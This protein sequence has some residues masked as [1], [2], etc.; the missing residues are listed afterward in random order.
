M[1]ALVNRA[2]GQLTRGCMVD[3]QLAKERQASGHPTGKAGMPIVARCSKCAQGT[4]PPSPHSVPRLGV[5]GFARLAVCGH[6]FI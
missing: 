2:E 3:G 6:V 4:R 5:G 1:A